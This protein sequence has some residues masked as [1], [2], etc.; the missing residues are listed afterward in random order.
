MSMDIVITK[1]NKRKA[2]VFGM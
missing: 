1:T 2:T